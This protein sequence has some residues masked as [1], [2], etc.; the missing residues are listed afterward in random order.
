MYNT[1]KLSYFKGVYKIATISYSQ[2]NF[3]YPT[4]NIEC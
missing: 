1:H 3:E 4:L 2:I